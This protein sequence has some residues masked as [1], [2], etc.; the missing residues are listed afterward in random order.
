[1]RIIIVF[2][3]LTG[4]LK[5][6]WSQTVNYRELFGDDWTRALIYENENRTW[7]SKVITENHIA[8]PLAISVI[9]PELVRYSALR[10][11]MEITLL[12]ALYVNL[13]EDYADFSIGVFQ[14]KPSFA[15]MIRDQAPDVI[16][17]MSP[18]VFK[19]RSAYDDIKAYRKSIVKDLE[20]P[21]SQV[22]YLVAFLRICE[23][24]FKTDRLDELSRVKFM[25]TAYNF[26]FNRSSEE[27]VTMTN[28]KFFNTSLYK[29]ESYSYADVSLYWYKEYMGYN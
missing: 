11:K 24:K 7:I 6:G 25:A 4:L 29:G 2:L 5:S 18:V 27:I 9:F 8:Y 1:V 12:K 3:L 22:N 14:M 20:D 17:G 21:K 19:N 23:K 16:G 13:G 10:D 15:E 26:S 28:K